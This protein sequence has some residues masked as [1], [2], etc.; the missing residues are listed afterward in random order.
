M[1]RNRKSDIVGG[2]DVYRAAQRAAREQP[3]PE[4]AESASD[5]A[6]EKAPKIGSHI[7]R[8]VLPTRHEV[9]CYEC[10]YEFQM[11]GAAK[12]TFCSKCRTNLTVENHVI[13]ADWSGELK[14]AGSVHIKEGARIESG[15]IMANHITLAGS[16]GDA[17]IQAFRWLELRPGVVFDPS[18]ML[19][20]DLR[21]AADLQLILPRLEKHHVEVAGTLK[22]VIVATGVVQVLAGG[23]IEG[24]IEGEH[25]VVEEGAG[26]RADVAIQPAV[27]S[28]AD[29]N[30]LEQ[31]A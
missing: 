12:S 28:A 6:R 10:G 20:R 26:L 13:Q 24:R 19:S 17:T 9:T 3:L 25:L 22:T 15:M 21:I 27:L 14:T 2:F 8:T 5:V 23:L 1:A 29:T 30:R 7:G 31:S 4:D 11:T 18:R 16:V